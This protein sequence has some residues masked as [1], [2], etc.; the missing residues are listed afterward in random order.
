M[1]SAMIYLRTNKITDLITNAE[2][3]IKI[4]NDIKKNCSMNLLNELIF[5]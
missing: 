2:L 5:K 1:L 3:D 4:L